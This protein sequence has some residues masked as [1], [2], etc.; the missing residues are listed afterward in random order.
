[1][2]RT[3]SNADDE[4]KQDEYHHQRQQIFTAKGRPYE[5]YSN[6]SNSN[7]KSNNATTKIRIADDSPE[8]LGRD[9]SNETQ[10][11]G[12]SSG[13]YS[14]DMLTQ[15]ETLS[16]AGDGSSSSEQGLEF[17]IVN[18]LGEDDG[19][20]E[21]EVNLDSSSVDTPPKTNYSPKSLYSGGSRT[22]NSNNNTDNNIINKSS[23]WVEDKPFDEESIMG[24]EDSIFHMSDKGENGVSSNGNSNNVMPVYASDVAREYI[25]PPVPP[26]KNRTMESSTSRDE[27]D[28]V[29]EI[30]DPENGQKFTP[31]VVWGEDNTH[32]TRS[33]NSSTYER[34][35]SNGSQNSKRQSRRLKL[36][37]AA[38]CVVTMLIILLL[39]IGIPL[40]KKNA[41]KDLQVAAASSSS[42]S[43]ASSGG[44]I[45]NSFTV[46]INTTGTNCSSVYSSYRFSTS[47]NSN[48]NSGSS[49]GR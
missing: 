32:G 38:C 23:S 35:S 5:G 2:F 15:M 25:L 47:S 39:A 20:V 3:F 7:N 49:L 4:M 41:D 12:D 6:S 27:V 1:M 21:D 24:D 29:I 33:I 16:E 17:N 30:T 31:R 28:D 26:T 48:R 46:F 19:E 44:E 9:R 10:T 11:T 45:I 42:S 40:S 43:S 22:Y 13:V 34:N 18:I 37:V 14:M 8:Y 36:L